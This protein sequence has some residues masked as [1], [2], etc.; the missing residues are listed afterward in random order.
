[1]GKKKRERERAE[2]APPEEEEEEDEELELE[3]R[4]VGGVLYLA[5]PNRTGAV[6]A[7]ERDAGGGLVRVGRLQGGEVELD[8]PPP[9]EAG[10]AEPAVQHAFEADPD[11]HCETSPEAY[12]DVAAVLAWYA[13][14]LGKKKKSL[15]IWDPYFCAGAVVR[16]LK[17]LGFNKVRNENKDFYRTL[18]TG[19]LPKHDVLLTNPPYSEVHVEKL[20]RHCAGSG[21]PWLLLMPNY[22]YMKPFYRRGT[23]GLDPVYLCPPKRYVYWTPKQFKLRKHGNSGP[24]GVRTSPFVSFWY[25][26]FPSPHHAAFLRWWRGRGAAG[27]GAP[28]CTLAPSEADLPVNMMDQNDPVRRKLRDRERSL[29]RRK[30]RR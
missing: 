1:M 30:K 7:A 29:K 14:R 6:Y 24:L 8:A 9:P 10:P 16:H 2:G 11:D 4:F 5:D 17:A 12:A 27:P 3:G 15:R 28:R 18:A 26:R 22:V 21:K 20:V 25:V 13:E 19:K 23:A